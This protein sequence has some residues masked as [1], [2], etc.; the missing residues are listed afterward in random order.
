M[1]RLANVEKVCGSENLMVIAM[2]VVFLNALYNTL[3]H[4]TQS[5][6]LLNAMY[7]MLKNSAIKVAVHSAQIALL[8]QCKIEDSL[9]QQGF[10]FSA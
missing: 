5:V 7:N 1:N 4:C 8:A 2:T 9:P 6:V 10:P 3:K